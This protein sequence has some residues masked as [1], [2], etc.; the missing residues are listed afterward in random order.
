MTGAPAEGY[1]S[2][3]AMATLEEV[4]KVLPENMTYAWNGMSYQET[5]ASGS[6]FAIFA[7]S[8]FFVFLI[9]AAQYESW[10]MPLS[11]LLG[12]PFALLGAFLFLWLARLIS[13]SYVNNIFAQISLVMLIAMAAK[14]A[15]LIVEYAEI[16]FHEG[17]SLFD[18]AIEAARLRFNQF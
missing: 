18:S 11:I 8:L 3:E 1:S 12:T 10:S 6:V 16:K 7:F 14:N 5:K 17:M 15:I 9:L 13:P 4:A 2:A